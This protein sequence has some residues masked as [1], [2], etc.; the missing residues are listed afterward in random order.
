MIVVSIK[1]DQGHTAEQL[2]ILVQLTQEDKGI[3]AHTGESKMLHICQSVGLKS[4]T[5]FVHEYALAIP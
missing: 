2:Q 5:V 1:N 3:P 4:A